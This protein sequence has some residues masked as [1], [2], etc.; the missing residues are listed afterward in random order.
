MHVS[1]GKLTD[2]GDTLG[3]SDVDL[4]IGSASFEKRCRSVLGNVERDHIKRALVAVNRTFGSRLDENLDW[5]RQR[6]GDRIEYLEV[7]SHDPVSSLVNVEQS[8]TRLLALRPRSVVVDITTFTRES[9]VMLIRV[10][11]RHR[12]QSTTV[13]FVY[14]TA[15]QY[16][17]GSSADS[18]RWLSAG[19]RNVRPVL[20]FTGQM[21]PSRDTHMIVMVGFEDERALELIRS[22]E[23]TRVSLGVCDP[24]EPGTQS[25]QDTNVQRLSRLMSVLPDVA[26]FEFPG[27]D[28]SATQ[29]VL[30]A[31]IRLFDDC[32]VV[33]APMNTKMS[34]VGAALLALQDQSIQL[35]YATPYFYNFDNYSLPGEDYYLF[36]WTAA[37]G[38]H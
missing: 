6:L 38:L 21:A 1:V 33:I 13:S 12:E 2:L 5:F 34:T 32:N 25:H 30:E 18:S 28:P 9:L 37:V 17:V 23:P 29:R 14:A 26:E 35:C 19:V 3:H 36:S 20:G 7:F 16:S 15:S 27:Y 22:C 24:R 4:F 11:Y 31:Q 8:V 10:L